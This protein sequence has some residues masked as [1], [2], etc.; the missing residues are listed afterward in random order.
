MSGFLTTALV[1][2]VKGEVTVSNAADFRDKVRE[3]L[4]TINRRPSN[5]IEFGQAEL[6][7]KGLREAESA[8]KAAK[9]KAISDAESI[10]L[11]FSLLDETSE[12]IRQARLELEKQI[13]ARKNE[14]K[15]ELIQEAFDFLPDVEPMLAR[16]AF[17]GDFI[18]AIKG[19]R[20]LDTMRNALEITAAV[21]TS[22]VLKCRDMLDEF[23]E[24]NGLQVILD[25]A[26]LELKTPETLEAELRRRIEAKRAAE[27]QQQLKDELAKAHAAT[28]AARAE[29][30]QVN[31]P[32]PPKPPKIGSIPTGSNEAAEW[33]GFLALVREAFFPL[34]EA[35]ER[36]RHQANRDKAEAFAKAIS[37]AW[38][39]MKGGAA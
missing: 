34:K 22:R 37:A 38:L 3:G 23:E 11:L 8:V 12:E 6:C 31:N 18:N 13:E 10:S 36:L 7:V 33:A 19:K 26:E 17:A 30:E 27:Q 1:V 35:R 14:V 29:V 32:E 5:D 24:S 39:E 20:T 16:R 25:R 15:D 2:E 28:E 21:I 4:A 9:Q